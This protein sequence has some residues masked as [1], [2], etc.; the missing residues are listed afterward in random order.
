MSVTRGNG[1]F[2]NSMKKWWDKRQ[3]WSGLMEIFHGCEL[4]YAEPGHVKYEFTV[5][6]SF[7]NIMDTMHGGCTFTML[8]VCASTAAYDPTRNTSGHQTGVTINMSIK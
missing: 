5:Q 6:D 1:I 3:Q 8:D 2:F 4:I 7:T